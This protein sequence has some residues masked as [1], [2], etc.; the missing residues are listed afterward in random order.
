MAIVSWFVSIALCQINQWDLLSNR[1]FFCQ[2]DRLSVGFYLWLNLYI[3]KF[4]LILSNALKA[5]TIAVVRFSSFSSTSFCVF[6]CYCNRRQ[7]Q[8]SSTST[9]THTHMHTLT[10]RSNTTIQHARIQAH[11]RLARER[12]THTS[13]QWLFIHG[14]LCIWAQNDCISWSD[15]QEGTFNHMYVCILLRI[16]CWY[17]NSCM[18]I[19]CLWP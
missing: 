9:H 12:E 13:F 8:Q 19:T 17:T 10:Q 18:R 6:F 11:S 15:M 5:Q 14:S 7:K 4:A 16:F 1:M 2:S 3:Y